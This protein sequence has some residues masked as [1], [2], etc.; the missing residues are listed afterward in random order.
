M[1]YVIKNASELSSLLAVAIKKEIV[2]E[3]GY[4]KEIVDLVV[5]NYDLENR[6]LGQMVAEIYQIIKTV[7]G[8]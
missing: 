6:G 4:P 5:N 3:S 8:E 7:A 1:S 2:R